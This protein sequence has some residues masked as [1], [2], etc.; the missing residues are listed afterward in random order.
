MVPTSPPATWFS[1]AVWLAVS[2]AVSRARVGT[3]SRTDR[4]G[5]SCSPRWSGFDA[6]PSP[7]AR[8]DLTVPPYFLPSVISH[9]ELK[10]PPPTQ[11]TPKQGKNIKNK[12][13]SP[14]SRSQTL[15][16]SS[17]LLPWRLVSAGVAGAGEGREGPAGR[18]REGDQEPWSRTGRG[19]EC[20]LLQAW[21]LPPPT[22]QSDPGCGAQQQG[23][24]GGGR[25]GGSLPGARRE[26]QTSK[27]H[28]G[29]RQ[30]LSLDVCVCPP[31]G[32]CFLMG[33]AEDGT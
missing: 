2:V 5:F 12:N 8:T 27:E 3:A 15:L 22:Q 18:P 23:A 33:S 31:R 24:S 13:K 17:S 11:P 32:G 29:S 30:D 26:L 28:P 6:G 21:P 20:Q 16:R 10:I 9:L 14:R 1:R 7:K 4:A 25:E 19:A